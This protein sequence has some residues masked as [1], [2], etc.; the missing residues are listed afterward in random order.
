MRLDAKTIADLTLPNGKSEQF[1]WD[2]EL[3]GFGFRLRQRGGR[4]HRTWIVQ[5][6]ANGRTRRPT[7]GPAEVLLA[8]EARTAARRSWP[9]W[10]L[11]AIRSGSARSS[12]RRRR[13]HS[14]P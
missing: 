14:L 12:G 8:P 13:G 11:V 4:L 3:R 2:D 6:R 1:H 10:R 9:V 5:Y 7:L